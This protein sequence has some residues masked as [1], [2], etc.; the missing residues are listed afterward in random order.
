MIVFLM[1]VIKVL[2]EALNMEKMTLS[3]EMSKN[4]FACAEQVYLESNPHI[5]DLVDQGFFKSGRQHYLYVGWKNISL[6][7]FCPKYCLDKSRCW[8]RQCEEDI[9]LR[10]YPDVHQEVL[11]E[12]SDIKSGFEHFSKF[13]LT[14]GRLWSCYEMD[15]GT[16]IGDDCKDVVSKFVQKT[17]SVVAQWDLHGSHNPNIVDQ[18]CKAVLFIDGRDDLHLDYVLRNHRRYTGPEWIFYLIAPQHVADIWKSRY[19]GPLVKIISLPSMFG[20]LT[21]YPDEIDFLLR[22]DYLWNDVVECEYVLVSQLDAL[23]LRSGVES[24]LS[25]AWVGGPIYPESFPS[26]D[27]RRVC[28]LSPHCGGNGGFSL[29]RKSFIL[30]ALAECSVPRAPYED[31]WFVACMIEMG[32]LLPSP[33]ISNTF[34]MG[35][36]CQPDNPVGMH[37]PWEVCSASVCVN[38]IFNSQFYFDIYKNNQTLPSDHCREGELQ[39]LSTDSA[40]NEAVRDGIFKSG[41]EFIKATHD[42]SALYL[43]F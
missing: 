5:K 4:P 30:R 31:V 28:A 25:Y 35:S 32:A 17:K 2:H 7:Y 14:E 41:Y 37:K 15:R 20:N 39:L 3:S 13:G 23:M 10:S 11:R 1:I 21:V 9:Y 43:C 18:N 12:S 24:Y 34:S 19:S 42:R 29:R 36:K 8:V 38:A 27:W 22:S 40:A 26:I 16:G 6:H 33:G